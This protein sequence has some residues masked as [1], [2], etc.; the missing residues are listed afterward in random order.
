MVLGVREVETYF[1]HP[2]GSALGLAPASL[3][4]WI[5]LSAACSESIA[6]S[7][8]VALVGK[9]VQAYYREV[10]EKRSIS[11]FLATEPPQ[12]C[13]KTKYS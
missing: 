8:L 7:V 2:A 3:Y 1:H 10:K 9:P 4:Y 12:A 11:V 5:F 13:V 6:P